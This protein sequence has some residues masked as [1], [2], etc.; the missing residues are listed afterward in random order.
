MRYVAWCCMVL[1]GATKLLL[2][3]WASQRKKS[4]LVRRS[5]VNL[6]L[7][8]GSSVSNCSLIVILN[9]CFLIVILNIDASF[10]GTSA[11]DAIHIIFENSNL[12]P[13]ANHRLGWVQRFEFSF[14]QWLIS[15]KMPLDCYL[16]HKYLVCWYRCYEYEKDQGCEFKS[17]P[18]IKLEL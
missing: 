17:P 13:L 9:I 4:D 5:A 11:F 12:Y 3:R 7:S 15:V 10:V 2:P 1:Y 6:A 14:N 8:N 18:T 16:E